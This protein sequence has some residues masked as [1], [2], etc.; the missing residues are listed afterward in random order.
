MAK[1]E[2]IF[3]LVVIILLSCAREENVKENVTD[4]IPS[5]QEIGVNSEGHASEEL[6]YQFS[7]LEGEIDKLIADGNLIGPD[8]YQRL[9]ERLESFENQMTKEDIENARLKLSKLNVVQEHPNQNVKIGLLSPRGCEGTGSFMLGTSPIALEDLQKILPMGM[10]SAVHITPTDHQYF[11]TI[12]Y[13]GPS[14]DTKNLDRYKIYAPA[15]GHIVEI[16][17]G[18]DHRIVIEHS[19]TFYTIFIHVDRISDKIKTFVNFKDDASREH[20][21]PRI[22]VKE[23]EVIGTIGIGKFDFSVVDADVVLKDFARKESYEGEPWKIHTVDTFDYFKEPVKSKLLEKNLR[24]IIPFGGKI[25]YDVDGK[26]AGNWFLQGTDG[27]K[28]LGNENYWASHLS[29]VYD[30]LDP[31]HIVVSIGDFGGRGDQFGVKGNIPDPKDVGVGTLV[32]YELVPYD[33]YSGNE[34]WD[35]IPYVEG[36]NARNQDEARGTALFEMIDSRKLKSEFFVGKNA[37]EVNGFTSNAK[38]YER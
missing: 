25:D 10:M 3:L 8:H 16:E 5:Q 17:K 18:T 35:G 20:A 32:K 28:G 24:K 14:D 19:C 37:N 2:T 27:Y 33:Y 21:W 13:F 6:R 1:K 12:G 38:I 9:N 31:S 34:K 11:H 23:G 7:L 36:I 30:A 26:L 4:N 29:I 15:D 22:P